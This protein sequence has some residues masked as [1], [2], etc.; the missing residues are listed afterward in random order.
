M[1]IIMSGEAYF[2]RNQTPLWFSLEMEGDKLAQKWD[3]WAA[4]IS[5]NAMKR[6]ELRD[7]D[8]EKW[9]RIAEKAADSRFEK[10]IIVI[11]DVHKPTPERV[12]MEVER[13]Q[14]DVTFVDTI[15]EIR[16]P[17]HLRSVWEQQGHAIRELK[18][19]CRTVKRPIVGIAQA[20][21]DA[22]QEGATLGNIAFSID[23]ARKADIV[24]G[25]HASKEMQAQ[26]KM[27]VRALKTRDSEGVGLRW[28]FKWDVAN[29][30]FRKWEPG[31]VMPVRQA[32]PA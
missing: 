11:D 22:E 8:Y 29:M 2:K 14:P 17:T 16:A 20:G 26:K 6:M 19:I 25:L 21:R 28:E 7:D 13:W 30:D 12:Y 9:A 15:D 3:A 31:D 24:L 10:D 5:Y 32:T 27:E 1:A 23:I 4:G 18:G